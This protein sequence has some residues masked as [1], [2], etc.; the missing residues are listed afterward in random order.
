MLPG[1][2]GAALPAGRVASNTSPASGT[3]SVERYTAS[4]HWPTTVAVPLFCTENDTL[5]V[6][7]KIALAGAAAV[8]TSKS[9]TWRFNA[10]A[11][12]L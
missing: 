12:T 11:L 5:T 4:V 6:S 8:A 10:E 1:P 7:P 9:T 3:A 2:S